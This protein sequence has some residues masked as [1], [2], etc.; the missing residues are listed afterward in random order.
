MTKKKTGRPKKNEATES[1]NIQIYCNKCD[2][3]L[4]VIG[5]LGKYNNLLKPQI[6]D[7]PQDITN[8]DVKK[9]KQKQSHHKSKSVS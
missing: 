1:N 8:V 7:T 2:T 9:Q 4:G 5:D 6:A 3:L